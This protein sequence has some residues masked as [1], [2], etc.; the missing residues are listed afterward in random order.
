MKNVGSSAAPESPPKPKMMPPVMIAP[1]TPL[2]LS[3]LRR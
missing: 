1:T 3:A 2:R